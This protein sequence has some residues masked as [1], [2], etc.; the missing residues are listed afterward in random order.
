[1]KQ[2]RLFLHTVGLLF[3]LGWC[4]PGWAFHTWKRAQL[5]NGLTLLVV[6]KHEA[7][8][9][10]VTLLVKRGA[11]SDPPDRRGV[12]F[13]TGR[14]QTEPVS[15]VELERVKQEVATRFYFDTEDVRDIARFLAEHEAYTQGREPP[16]HVLAALRSVTAA[17]I[18]RV[19]RTYLDPQR[20]VVIVEGDVQALR[21]YAPGLAQGKL[22]QWDL[23]PSGKSDGERRE[24]TSSTDQT[25]R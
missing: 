21:K 10:A 12:A 5:P 17:E 3:L 23:A 2:H 13:L 9:V 20:A 1:M 24:S 6:E 7:P 11:T 4:A 22:P 25:G 8:V 19:A 16:D 18:Q 15:T 14:L